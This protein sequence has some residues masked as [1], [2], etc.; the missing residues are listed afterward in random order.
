MNILPLDI[1]GNIAE[2]IERDNDK[3]CL[4]MTCK[5]ISECKF[6]FY[7]TANL[8]KISQSRWFNYFTNIN[9]HDIVPFPSH[10]KH[11]TFYGS[12]DKNIENKI[13]STVTHLTFGYQ[14]DQ[15]IVGCIPSSVKK[16][17]FGYLFNQPIENSI[18]SNIT[19]L[20]FGNCFNQIITNNIP[21]TTTHLIFNCQFKH[22]IRGLSDL[23]VTH[24]TLCA[25]YEKWSDITKISSIT[26][27]IFNGFI[28]EF[29]ASRIIDYLSRDNL[30]IIFQEYH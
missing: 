16:M 18:P 2:F 23:S 15:P 28:D 1:I 20:K 29:K 30:N 26:N 3:C 8:K 7:Q 19:Y 5:W 11:L 13:P 22:S 21:K 6:R 24:L 17:E 25:C 4:M 14:F 27:L 10:I 12:F 9:A